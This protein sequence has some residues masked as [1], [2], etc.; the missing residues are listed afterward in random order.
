MKNVIPKLMEGFLQL[1]YPPVCNVCGEQFINDSPVPGICQKC[2][3]SFQ[4]I[5]AGF[6]K[7]RILNRLTSINLDTLHVLFEFDENL[8]QIIH[9][10]KYRKMDR[11]AYGFGLYCQSHLPPALLAKDAL[12]LPVPLH[13]SREKERGYNQS[14]HIARGLFHT[15]KQIIVRDLFTRRRNTKS[16]TTLDRQ[17][18]QNN[19]KDAFEIRNPEKV[20]SK[21]VIIVDDVVTTGATLNECAGNL[22]AFGVKEVIGLALAAPKEHFN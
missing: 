1:I 18:R 20:L 14:Y 17:Q 2:L 21:T 15:Q 8:Q 19:V 16:Q 4:T 13:P 6:V 7:E 9:S 3:D 10:I 12:V 5:S 22:K 11:L